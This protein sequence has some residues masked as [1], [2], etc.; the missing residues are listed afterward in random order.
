MAYFQPFVDENGYHFPTYQDILEDLVAQMKLIYGDDI[1]LE[2]D[3]MDY[4]F[5][6][7]ISDKIYDS[8]QQNQL[9]FVNRSPS[10][11]I[12]GV[13]MD[14]LFTVNGI[15]RKPSTKSTCIVTI[16]GE[17]LTRIEGGIVQDVNG[18]LWD[19][20]TMQ[21]P[22][23]GTINITA[24]CQVAGKINALI[25]DINQIYTPQAGWSSVYNN[26]V[27][28]QGQ[29][30]ETN[31]EFRSRQAISTSLP[32]LTVLE[33]LGG[34]I[35]QLNNITRFKLYEN[36]TN[37]VDSNGL[38]PH[39]ISL[40]IEGGDN[41]EIAKTIFLK[42]TMGCYTYG[43]TTVNVI[44]IYG[45]INPIRFF[46]PIIKPFFADITVKGLNGYTTDTTQK[47][48]ETIVE[49]VN[50]L[51]I[52]NIVSINV[53]LNILIKNLIEDVTNPIFTINSSDILIGATSST[54]NSDINL[55]FNEV[56]ESSINN[57]NVTVI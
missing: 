23:S 32:S 5:L 16:T 13:A 37:L 8:F 54:T 9:N 12:G 34:A 17:P 57:I 10:T 56:V 42:K 48:K 19:I 4:Q 28:I 15:F 35:A 40:V 7:I 38:P 26:S 51:N 45:Q 31:Q 33:G 43:T 6:S 53:I 47:I 21:I 18:I 46:R 55:L 1:Y 20:P 49:Y 36:D 39:S 29:N 44:D 41:E 3:S 25:G 27:A 24:R 30:I 50:K 2:N 22:V 14:T 11:V 52:G